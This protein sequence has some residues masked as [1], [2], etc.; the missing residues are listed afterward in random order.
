METVLAVIFL[1]STTFLGVCRILGC[2][3]EQEE[4]AKRLQE[5]RLE[6]DALKKMLARVEK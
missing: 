6:L 4:M 1:L 5:K 2:W 3:Y